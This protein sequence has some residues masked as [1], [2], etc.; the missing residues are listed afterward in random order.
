[1]KNAN[2]ILIYLNAVNITILGEL[3]FIVAVR[4]YYVGFKCTAQ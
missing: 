1:M 2:Y 3:F 4:Q